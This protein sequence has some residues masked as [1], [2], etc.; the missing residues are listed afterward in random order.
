ME[1]IEK[2]LTSICDIERSI[3]FF[4]DRIKKVEQS[5]DNLLFGHFIGDG[6][7]PI[8]MKISKAKVMMELRERLNALCDDLRNAKL[9]AIEEFHRL[10]KEWTSTEL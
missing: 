10:E 5:K 8:L 3:V 1:E 9:E 4:E 6:E 2:I 7:P